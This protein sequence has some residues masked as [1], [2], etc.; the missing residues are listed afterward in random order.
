MDEF[1]SPSHFQY[2]K[3][4]QLVPPELLIS[5]LHN[6]FTSLLL[7]QIFGWLQ[8]IFHSLNSLKNPVDLY[9]NYEK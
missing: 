6:I 5:L 3:G 7:S 2:K 1:N 9:G 8:V 4:K